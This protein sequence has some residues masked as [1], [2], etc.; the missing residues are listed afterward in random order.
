[1]FY[2]L[3]QK[4]QLKWRNIRDYYRKYT[5]KLKKS[6]SGAVKR[7]KY[8]YADQLG[9]LLPVLEMR[10]ASAC[11]LQDDDSQNLEDHQPCVAEGNPD[12]EQSTSSGQYVRSHAAARS[13]NK[14]KSKRTKEDLETKLCQFLDNPPK[15]IPPVEDEDKSFFDSLLPT[16]RTFDID[17]KIEFRSEVLRVL[18]R[19]RRSKLQPD[20]YQSY[21]TPIQALPVHTGHSG[22]VP[23]SFSVLP[24]SYNRAPDPHFFNQSSTPHVHLQN[25][26]TQEINCTTGSQHSNQA[27]QPHKQQSQ[28]TTSPEPTINLIGCFSPDSELSQFSD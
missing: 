27:P 24:N 12:E 16:V 21:Q 10:N 14:Q 13:S 20:F 1:M 25:Q 18:Q 15:P 28:N 2:V 8:V 4:L 11:S 22:Y 7:F 9:F 5:R 23:T 3:G 6:G 26:P 19:V 17:Q